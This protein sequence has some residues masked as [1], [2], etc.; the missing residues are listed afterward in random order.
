MNERKNCIW[1][2]AK[3]QSSKTAREENWREKGEHI[4]CSPGD[5]MKEKTG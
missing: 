3:K 5:F 2:N 1:S 4:L